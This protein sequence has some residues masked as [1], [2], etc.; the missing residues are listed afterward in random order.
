MSFNF[1]CLSHIINTVEGLLFMSKP[2]SFINICTGFNT[3]YTG[4]NT[5]GILFTKLDFSLRNGIS[6][7]IMC[8]NLCFI[9]YLSY[10]GENLNCIRIFYDDISKVTG[11][12]QIALKQILA[13]DL[14]HIDRGQ[15]IQIIDEIEIFDKQSESDNSPLDEIRKIIMEGA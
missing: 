1:D 14:Q 3:R 11:S 10:E 5:N 15:S 7:I 9:F 4:F 2:Q 12:F 6:E 13:F 8:D